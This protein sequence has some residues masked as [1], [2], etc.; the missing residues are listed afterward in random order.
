MLSP[1]QIIFR[2]DLA[3]KILSQEL[4]KCHSVKCWME[5]LN[6]FGKEIFT[7]AFKKITHGK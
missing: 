5:M 6:G 1:E 2:H 3:I 4:I 7:E